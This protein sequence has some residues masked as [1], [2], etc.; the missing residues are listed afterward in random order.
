MF[1]QLDELPEDDEEYEPK[2]EEDED[3]GEGGRSRRKRR[4]TFHA[5]GGSRTVAMDGTSAARPLVLQ[6]P[7][8]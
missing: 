6:E 1:E 5:V 4:G 8:E 7:P 2:E 3:P